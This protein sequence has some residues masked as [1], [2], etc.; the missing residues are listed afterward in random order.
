MRLILEILPRWDHE[1]DMR[2]LRLEDGHVYIDS[3]SEF[4]DLLPPFYI[5]MLL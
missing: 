5:G 2:R 3:S 4:R 1:E